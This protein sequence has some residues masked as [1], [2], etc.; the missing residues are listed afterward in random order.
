MKMSRDHIIFS[1]MGED[2]QIAKMVE[3]LKEI[4]ILCKLSVHQVVLDNS[5]LLSVLTERQ[6]EL[7]LLAKDMGYY[8]YPRK[9]G[10]EDLAAAMGLSAST[11]IEHLRKSEVRLMDEIMTGHQ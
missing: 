10:A 2:D 3:L 4:G 1:F 5:D 9:V 6:R 8:K 7:L 11:V